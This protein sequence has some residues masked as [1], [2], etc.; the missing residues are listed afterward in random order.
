[1]FSTLRTASLLYVIDKNGDMRFSI[2]RNPKVSAPYPEYKTAIP[3]PNAPMLVDI[4]GEDG[5]STVNYMKIPASLSSHESGGIFITESREAAQAE[6]E[7]MTTKSKAVLDSIPY[8]KSVI[9]FCD[10]TLPAVN[11]SIAQEKERE[12][13]LNSLEARMGNIETTLSEL[14]STLKNLKTA[15]Q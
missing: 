3:M 6:L 7:A 14:N 12:N 5:N 15:Q 11:P 1:M 4:T 2:V 13:K 9:E 8:H 10:K